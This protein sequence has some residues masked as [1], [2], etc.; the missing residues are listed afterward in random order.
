MKNVFCR[1]DIGVLGDANGALEWNSFSFLS[2][3]LYGYLIRLFSIQEVMWHLLT[4]YWNDSVAPNAMCT[5]F[6]VHD[7][8]ID[9]VLKK[10]HGAG[11]FFNE[12][13]S[14]FYRQMFYAT[15]IFACEWPLTNFR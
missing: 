5:V 10:P 11:D 8:H 15:Q 14:D 2:S 3:G 6:L 12:T 7:I 1:S 13:V 9:P 4:E